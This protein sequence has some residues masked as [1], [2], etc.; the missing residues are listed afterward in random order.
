MKV[1][2]KIR[3]EGLLYALAIA[4]N[5]IVPGWLF[6]FTVMDVLEMDPAKIKNS[7]RGY[8]PGLSQ[9]ITQD[10]R[11]SLQD[12]SYST[13]VDCARK[14]PLAYGL[15][16]Q[17]SG[18]LI[19]GLWIGV[20]QHFEETFGFLFNLP[21]SAGWLFAATL[22]QE[23]RGKGHYGDLLTYGLRE[24]I[25]DGVDP[26]F[27]AVS[28]VYRPAVE[29]HSKFSKR[30]V[31]RVFGF[32]FLSWGLVKATDDLK[33]EQ[34]FTFNCLKRPNRIRVTRRVSE[35]TGTESAPVSSTKKP[36]LSAVEVYASGLE[37]TSN[38][39]F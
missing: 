18:E 31:G 13:S 2:E 32:K 22:K 39:E 30:K 9:L 8:R 5:R 20:Q 21:Q 35:S 24:A 4:F 7:K 11:E 34:K 15:T 27:L 26:I 38:A 1:F 36:S 33:V 14:Y 6:T 19:G 28:P 29:A 12:L 17:D 37:L 25:K 23:H 16:N 10:S 3:Q